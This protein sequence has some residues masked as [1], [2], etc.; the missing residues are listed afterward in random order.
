MAY[1][2]NRSRRLSNRIA[3][4]LFLRTA[5]MTTTCLSSGRSGRS[6]TRQSHAQRPVHFIRRRC[7][8]RRNPDSF[9]LCH[10]T[11]WLKQSVWLFA[12]ALVTG[13]FF[14][15]LARRLSRFSRWPLLN[16]FLEVSVGRNLVPF[17][18][19]ALA[20]SKLCTC[21]R[22]HFVDVFRRCLSSLHQPVTSH[23]GSL[24]IFANQDRRDT[25]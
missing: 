13:K 20:Q 16:N 7:N 2:T 8:Q 22:L 19:Q 3:D 6:V 23:H 4:S 25:N 9:R 14:Q 24:S 10:R 15:L 17:H 1:S 18:Q 12:G 21:F 11:R 5:A